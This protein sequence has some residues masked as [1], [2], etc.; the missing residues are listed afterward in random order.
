MAM[1]EKPK[2]TYLCHINYYYSCKITKKR[3]ITNHYM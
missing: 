3:E 1:D 2:Y